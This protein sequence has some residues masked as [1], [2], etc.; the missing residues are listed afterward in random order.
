MSLFSKY[1]Y[2]R[3]EEKFLDGENT[4]RPKYRSIN[5]ISDIG[6]RC[7]ENA[8]GIDVDTVTCRVIRKCGIGHVACPSPRKKY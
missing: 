6:I 2:Q 1:R 8:V 4:V 7:V 3:D 5:H